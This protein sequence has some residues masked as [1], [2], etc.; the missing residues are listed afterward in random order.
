MYAR[1]VG[2]FFYSTFTN[3]G[4]I[5]AGCA[6]ALTSRMLPKIAGLLGIALILIGAVVWWQGMVVVGAVLLVAAPVE[7]LLPLA[8]LGRRAYSLYL[9]SWPFVVLFGGLVALPL[10]FAAAEVSYRF[11]ERPVLDRFHARLAP[12]GARSEAS[13]SALAESVSG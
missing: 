2:P 7:A 9:W 8:P 11:V 4:A 3:G 12:R 6:A 5:L 1:D 10:T 13:P